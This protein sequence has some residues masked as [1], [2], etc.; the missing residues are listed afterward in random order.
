MLQHCDRKSLCNLKS[1]CPRIFHKRGDLKVRQQVDIVE[2]LNFVSL[3]DLLKANM[4]QVGE[5]LA[6]RLDAHPAVRLLS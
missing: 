4:S 2:D 6:G 3:L 1:M 5:D